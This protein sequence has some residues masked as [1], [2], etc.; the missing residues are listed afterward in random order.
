MVGRLSRITL[1]I[2]YQLGLLRELVLMVV[3]RK[4]PRA[5]Q[6]REKINHRGNG[7][8][9]SDWLQ[10]YLIRCQKNATTKAF[11]DIHPAGMETTQILS[12]CYEPSN[13]IKWS[14][15]PRI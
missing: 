4:G 2:F 5:D 7:V 13:G 10:S 12:S 15:L 9:C 14:G 3:D 11:E 6:Y 1:V 8:A